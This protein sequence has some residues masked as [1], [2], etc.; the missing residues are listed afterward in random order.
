[1]ENEAE[2]NEEAPTP[3]AV[4]QELMEQGSPIGVTEDLMARTLICQN[5]YDFGD[6]SLLVPVDLEAADL[7]QVHVAFTETSEFSLF[8]I[9]SLTTSFLLMQE[10][11]Y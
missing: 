8:M 6:E 10:T 3:I 2:D 7:G 1:M 5:S 4:W 11:N 9:V